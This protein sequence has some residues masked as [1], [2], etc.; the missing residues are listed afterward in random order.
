MRLL[1]RTIIVV[2]TAMTCRA[3]AD[4]TVQVTPWTVA[5]FGGTGGDSLS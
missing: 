2:V 5:E 3:S 1:L 4:D